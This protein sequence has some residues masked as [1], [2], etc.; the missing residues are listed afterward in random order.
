MSTIFTLMAGILIAAAL[1][2]A[3]L[4]SLVQ[5]V[6]RR[7]PL[8]WSHAAALALTIVG[9]ASLSLASPSL[10]LLAG[11]ALTA[12]ALLAFRFET[13]W[14]RLLPLFQAGFG[15]ALATGLPFASG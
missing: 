11:A 4:F 5:I 10:A 14:N 8:R 15:L 3:T 7:G 6:R 13:G 9:M 12:A 2:A 1:F